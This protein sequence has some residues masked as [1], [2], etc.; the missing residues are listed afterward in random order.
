MIMKDIARVAAEIFAELTVRQPHQDKRRREGLALL[1]AT[2]LRV[3]SVNLNALAA[4][5]PRDPDRLDMRYQW[6]SRVLGND[7]IDIDATMGSFAREAAERCARDGHLFLVTREE[8]VQEAHKV[9]VVS[10]L[11]GDRTLPLAWRVR[12]AE[13]DHGFP[14]R[15]EALEAAAATLP[16]G[17]DAT[18]LGASRDHAAEIEG[19]CR[20]TGWEWRRL[21]GEM[22][23]YPDPAATLA[24]GAV[25]GKEGFH[26]GESRIERADRLDRLVL[27]L[28]LAL[29]WEALGSR[30]A[31]AERRKGSLR[32]RRRPTA[33]AA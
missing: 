29:H 20:S 19:W 9:F 3:R 25:F 32:R 28:A 23:D 6:I 21:D 31:S 15:R 8:L 26:L 12:G 10:T 17:V 18:L 2:A 24:F 33:R 13:E 22:Q 4:A 16:G 14:W 30:R 7:H 11:C 27:V 5:L 1:T